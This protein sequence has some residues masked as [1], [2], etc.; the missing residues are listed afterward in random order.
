MEKCKEREPTT[1]LNEKMFTNVS[2]LEPDA[3]TTCIRQSQNCNY[4]LM[5]QWQEEYHTS[6]TRD[7]DGGLIYRCNAGEAVIP[8][9]IDLKQHLMDIHH[10]HPMA[11][12][13]G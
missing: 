11:G 2:L 5:K 13:P 1:V 10:N 4:S 6:Y 8:P 12:H 9:D 3:T 7:P